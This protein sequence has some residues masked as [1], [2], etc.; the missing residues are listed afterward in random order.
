MRIAIVEDDP[1]MSEQLRSYVLQYFEGREVQCRIT[2]FSD[3]DEIVEDYEADYDLI[4]L[5]IQLQ[6]L[7]GLKT[8]ERIRELDEAVYLIF[9]TNLANYAI[10]GYSV[11]ALDF[12]LKPVNY[13]MLRQLLQRVERLMETRARKYIALPTERGLTRLEVNQIYYVETEN[14]AVQVYTSK[15]VWRLRESMRSMESLLTE[16]SFFRCNSCYLINLAH[17][18]KVDGSTVLVAGH[19]LTISRP[20]HKAFMAA[21]TRYIGGI[22]A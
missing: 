6:R 10:K 18:E 1:V 20:R 9:I 16:H 7:D 3:G 4:F 14:H 19:A 5:D 15:G 22:K 8:A 2:Q 13:L 17:V 21:L 11:N 12:V